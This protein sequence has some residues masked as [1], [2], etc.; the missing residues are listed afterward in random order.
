MVVLRSLS[1]MQRH[2]SNFVGKKVAAEFVLA[3]LAILSVALLTF[4]IIAESNVVSMAYI[5]IID[6]IIS[7]IFLAHWI[8]RLREATDKRAF[9]RGNWW[10]LVASVPAYFEPTGVL[11]FVRL[12]VRLRILFNTSRYFIKHAYSL[13]IFT[14]FVTIL[15]AGADMFYA[16]EHG[17][18]EAVGSFFDCVWWAMV[19]I[20]TVG[21]GDISPVTAGGRIVGMAM[22]MLGI[23]LLGLTTGRVASY[24]VKDQHRTPSKDVVQ[25]EPQT[26]AN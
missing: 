26:P 6:G 17:T 15:F 22:M 12:A 23:G 3:S 5:Y 16:F 25:S 8:S 9:L 19:T 7:L 4:E 2:L 1:S 18:N 10:E 21:Y 11:R 13:E 24:L 20:T 14:I